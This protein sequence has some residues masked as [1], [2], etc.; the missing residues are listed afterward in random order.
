MGDLDAARRSARPRREAL[1]RPR[2]AR[3]RASSSTSSKGQIE[4]AAGRPERAPTTPTARAQRFLETLR[5]SLRGEELKIAFMKNKLEVYERL[6]ELSLRAERRRGGARGGVR[7]RGAGEVAQPAGPDRSGGRARSRPTSPARASSS[8]RVGDLREELNWY[9]H[10][11]EAE[12]MAPEERTAER[13][14]RLQSQVQAHENEL[15]R[16]LRELPAVGERVGWSCS[17]R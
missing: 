5:S 14:E 11:I 1:C 13:I 6:V 15:L 8:R 4:Q 10:R 17:R 12:Q 3:A 9:Y 2:P 16:V 7:L